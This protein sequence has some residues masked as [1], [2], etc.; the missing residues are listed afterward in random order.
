MQRSCIYLGRKRLDG[1]HLWR[2]RIAGIYAYAWSFSAGISHFCTQRRAFPESPPPTAGF[3]LE[4]VV[5]GAK[6][7]EVVNT[8]E[9]DVLAR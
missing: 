5:A 7:H 3:R 4:I 8:S 9:L 1:H 6:Y 2:G